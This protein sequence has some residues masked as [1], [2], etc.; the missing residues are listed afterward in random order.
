MEW[1]QGVRGMEVDIG[2][3]PEMSLRTTAPS[4]VVK[5]FN[6]EDKV[7]EKQVDLDKIE[8]TKEISMEKAAADLEV[9]MYP[10]KKVIF[11]CINTFVCS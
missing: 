9:K 6:A 4:V 3:M 5:D 8:W 1:L 7:P 10:F 2:Y 11:V